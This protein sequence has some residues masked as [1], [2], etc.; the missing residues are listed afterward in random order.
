MNDVM[1]DLETLGTSSDSVILS[2]GAV[3]FNSDG[4]EIG[5]KFYRRIDIDSCLEYG[6]RVSGRTLVWWLEQE[7]EAR[8]AITRDEGDPLAQVLDDL[9]HFIQ[10]DDCIWGNG[11]A[12][13]N[14]ILTYAF[15]KVGIKVPWKFWNDRCFR[16]MKALN[17]HV[18]RPPFEGVAH[19]ALDDAI[20]QAKHLQAILASL[21]SQALP[22][23]QVA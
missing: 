23:E 18:V 21:R 13:D 19:H 3:R 16:T 20:S 5:E 14:A 17:R 11:A 2:I 22:A 9:S 7:Y 4:D 8:M 1:I 12:F 6:L 15:H 10:P